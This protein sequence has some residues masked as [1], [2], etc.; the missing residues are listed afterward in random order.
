MQS[1]HCTALKSGHLI[2]QDRS[3]CIIGTLHT[4]EIRT[5]LIYQDRSP[6]IIRTLYTPGIRTPD[7]PGQVTLYNQDTEIRTHLIYQDRCLK[8]CP[9]HFGGFHCALHLLTSIK[10]CIVFCS[11]SYIPVSCPTPCYKVM[12]YT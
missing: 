11:K 4:P 10:A 5:H 1:G 7:L 12:V 2:Y 9:M 6:C 8:V 3:P